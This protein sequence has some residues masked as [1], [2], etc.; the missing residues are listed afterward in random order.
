MTGL[1]SWSKMST[2]DNI[3]DIYFPEGEH[4]QIFQN[5]TD[6]SQPQAIPLEL[7]KQYQE[8]PIL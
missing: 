1:D 8:I 6:L 2:A 3:P 5:V 7:Q 4:G